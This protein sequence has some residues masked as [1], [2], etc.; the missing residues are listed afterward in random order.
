MKKIEALLYSDNKPVSIEIA[1]GFIHKVVP[2][3][4]PEQKANKKLYVAPGLIDNQV[5]GYL[6]VEFTS[7]ELTTEDVRKVVSELRKTGVTTF[8]PTVITASNEKLIKSF[9]GLTE[10]RHDPEIARSIPG[11]HLEGPYISPEKGYRGAH[12]SDE[13]RRPDW[14]EFQK[15]NEAAEGKIL[16]V[17]LAPEVEGSVDFIRKCVEQGIV[18]ALGHHNASADEIT[19]AVDAGARTVTHLGN[20][21][22]NTIHRFNNPFWIQLAEDRLMASVI[23]D[24]IHVLPEQAKVFYKSK[25]SRRL[26]LTS[27]ITMLA[28][29]PPG[30]YTWDG[31]EVVLAPDGCIRYPQGN[32]F[33]GA[34]LPLLTGI[35]NIMRFTGCTLGEAINM[36][37]GNPARLYGFEDRGVIEVGKRADLI[38]FRMEENQIHI[39]KSIMAG[40]VLFDADK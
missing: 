28:G 23:L 22:A 20:G 36:A 5:N 19:R 13:I 31:K 35:N 8:L 21:C 4:A 1:E 18:I 29:M 30:N 16:Q 17:T 2:L 40:E 24:G 37:S 11:F 34:S 12:N 6:G 32:S 25:G 14:D 3:T 9:D 27:D 39:N 26:I 7:S 38:L 10:A 15:L 33:A